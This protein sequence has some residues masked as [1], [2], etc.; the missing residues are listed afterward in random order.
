MDTV[1]RNVL[2]SGERCLRPGRLEVHHVIPL[3]D[4]GATDPYDLANLRTLCRDCHI[5]IHLPAP[6]PGATAWA[7]ARGRAALG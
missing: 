5:R 3:A 7:A 6:I 2:P 4:G 1:A